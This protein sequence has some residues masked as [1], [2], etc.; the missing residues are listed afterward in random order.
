MKTVADI[1]KRPEI[2]EEL[3]K[4]TKE[5]DI[6]VDGPTDETKVMTCDDHKENTEGDSENQKEV[7]D[8]EK[9]TA[10][11]KDKRH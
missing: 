8:M 2:M 7:V 4:Y 11:N 3:Q 1:V 6:H 9:V 10:T 5:S